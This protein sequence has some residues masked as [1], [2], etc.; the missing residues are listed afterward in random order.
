LLLNWQERISSFRR[1][2]A[3]MVPFCR[4]W[5]PSVMVALL[6]C[7]C[8]PAANAD[9]KIVI[10]GNLPLTGPI[11]AFSGQYP[12]GLTMGIEDACKQLAVPADKFKIDF[13]DNAGQPS[14][15]VSI[16]RKQMM[17]RMDFY[18]SG[19]SPESLA[20]APEVGNQKV[21][22]LMVAFDAF[23]CRNDQ[24]RLRI[25]PHFKLEGPVYVEYAK[26]R[27]AKRVFI[28]ANI[29]S[30]YNDELDKIVEPG[31]AKLGI[32]YQRESFE[33]GTK[34]YRTIAL[35]ASKYKP[36]LIFIAGF[37]VHIYPILGA[38]RQYGLIKDGN[39]LSTMDFIDLLH[40]NTAKAELTDLPFI[41][42]AF[43]L[44][45][46]QSK[47]AVSDWSRRYEKAYKKSPS[48]VEAYAY[49]TGRILVAAYKKSGRS[50]VKSIRDVLP[51]HGISG[52]IALDQDG[53]LSIKLHVAKVSKDG[54]VSAIE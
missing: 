19:V 39:V 18:I 24:N 35:K 7:I 5:L 51:F 11:A 2:L 3:N 9:G 30:A 13:Q 45:S 14:R 29:N 31:L 37:S 50:D 12:N 10:D 26:K 43:E 16:L 41:T 33:F 49:D 40:N 25:F 32:E 53:D 34:D 20:I 28:I 54:K 27:H 23:I 6:V 48:Y 38:L 47:P 22:H 17:D 44:S 42:P 21:P 1:M 46:I 4:P 15:A 36:D 8:S 52:D